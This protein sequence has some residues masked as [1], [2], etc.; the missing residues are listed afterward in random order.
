MPRYFQM[1]VKVFEMKLWYLVTN[2]G[3]NVFTCSGPE[4]SWCYHHTQLSSDDE[5][6]MNFS[7]VF[8]HFIEILWGKQTIKGLWGVTFQF[9]KQEPEPEPEMCRNNKYLCVRMSPLSA[10]V[11]WSRA[12]H[13]SC[14]VKIVVI[15][16]KNKHSDWFLML[17]AHSVNLANDGTITKQNNN[18]KEM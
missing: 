7:D 10:C 8:W 3:C 6:R 5:S 13:Q 11:A 1:V 18:N 4:Q 15:H 14:L 17:P 9:L 16:N 2:G 12:N